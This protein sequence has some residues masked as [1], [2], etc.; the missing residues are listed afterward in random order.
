MR[1]RRFLLVSAGAA[2]AWPLV[3]GAQQPRGRMTRVAVL[4][5]VSKNAQGEGWYGASRETFEQLGWKDGGNVAIDLRWGGGDIDHIRAQAVVLVRSKPDVIMCYSVRVVRA[6]RKDTSDIPIVFVPT[7]D[8]VAQGIVASFAHPGSNLTGFTL[9]EFSVVGKLVELAKQIVPNATQVAVLFNPENTSAKG[10]LRILE[11]IAPKLGVELVP[12]QVRDVATIEAGIGS[13]ARGSNGVLLLPPDVTTQVYREP[14][15]AAAAQ[16]KIVAIYSDRATVVAGG[17][18]AYGTDL[19]GQ[20]SGAATYVDR[21]L[22]GEK[23]A[24]LPVQ[25]PT[26]YQLMINMKTARALGL[27]IP[28]AIL[29]RADEVIE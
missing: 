18:I 26:R 8:P 28:P 10:Y 2:A 25:A 22:K 17:L 5:G 27:T 15:I 7:A 24:D 1:R 29:A 23:P 16:H 11:D 9:Y 20:F 13:F 14:A 6:L 3:A 19:R 21:I 4:M 12:V